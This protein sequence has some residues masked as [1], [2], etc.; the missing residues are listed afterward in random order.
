VEQ[1][2]FKRRLLSGVATLEPL[3]TCLGRS[4]LF[5][6]GGR[7]GWDGESFRRLL[8]DFCCQSRFYS[9]RF[10]P[11]WIVKD[12]FHR[13]HPPFTSG[14]RPWATASGIHELKRTVVVLYVASPPTLY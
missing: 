6:R 14:R 12:E 8:V 5:L 7:C 2:Q 4:P 11:F 3:W 10:D 9:V 1:R 13:Q